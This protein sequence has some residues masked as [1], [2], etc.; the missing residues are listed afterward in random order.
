MDYH[1]IDVPSRFGVIKITLECEDEL[2]ADELVAEI[3]TFCSNLDSVLEKAFKEIV[4]TMLPLKNECWLDDN[5]APISADELLQATQSGEISISLCQG[6]LAEIFF[7]DGNL[8][9]GHS[10]VVWHREDGVVEETHLAG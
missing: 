10:I 7:E 1:E 6:G 8:F 9:G 3:R 5:E 2:S 4:D